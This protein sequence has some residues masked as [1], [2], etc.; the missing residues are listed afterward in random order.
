VVIAL[1][2]LIPANQ[3]ESITVIGITAL[4]FVWGTPGALAAVPVAAI[5][6]GV[7]LGVRA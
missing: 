2:M 3:V 7:W 5:V 4:G 1:G 6:D